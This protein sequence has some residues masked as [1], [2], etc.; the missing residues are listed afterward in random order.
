[1]RLGK[2]L[3]Y[4]APLRPAERFMLV[5]V[6]A[7]AVVDVA[8][9]NWR[10]TPVDWSGY[11]AITAFSS[12]VLLIGFF[13]R[14]TE[15]SE[16]LANTLVSTAS[17]VLFTMV[18]S[19][20]TYQLL[21]VWRAPID[22][23]L[24]N[25]D[26]M[27][28]FHWPDALALAADNPW[29]GE[30]TRYAYMSSLPQFAL[31]VLVLG[32]SG[33]TYELHIFMLATVVSCLLTIAVWAL[34]PS[35][36]TTTVFEID[37]AVEA[38]LRP[39]V[40]SAYGAE[41]RRLAAEGPTLISSKDALG[42]IAAPSFHTVMALLAVYA[43]RTVPWLWPGALAVNLMVLPGVLIHGGHHLVDVLAGATVTVLGILAAKAALRPAQATYASA[44]SPVS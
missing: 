7:L 35:F 3:V 44:L 38:R 16:L 10:G 5:S 40:G 1:M 17:F 15:R 19:A 25:L 22:P 11:A 34:F 32:F 30:A 21:P 18:A 26:G 9:V 8:A 2:E 31:L 39:L 13:Y 12:I 36:G 33:R 29:L 14:L 23:W 41:L 28:G 24:M 37:S 43:A 4:A 6:L 27:L 20:F 42:L